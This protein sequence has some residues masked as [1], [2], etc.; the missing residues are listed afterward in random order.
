MGNPS[1][2]NL[3]PVIDPNP[4]YNLASYLALMCEIMH[5]GINGLAKQK[6]VSARTSSSKVKRAGLEVYDGVVSDLEACACD[7]SNSSE[8]TRPFTLLFAEEAHFTP[9]PSVY[10]LMNDTVYF[11]SRDE[12]LNVFRVEKSQSRQSSVLLA[13]IESRAKIYTNS[14]R[15]GQLAPN[16]EYLWGPIFLHPE[17]SLF[18]RFCYLPPSE[19]GQ[20][21]RAQDVYTLCLKKSE[22]LGK[23]VW[24]FEQ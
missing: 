18:C 20:T 2:S 13:W 17:K 19:T 22:Y 8:P 11:G 9:L 7:I 5:P 23:Y 15:A 21:L 14:D 12:E 24:Q 3:H 1:Y 10:F 4:V 6:F 16:N